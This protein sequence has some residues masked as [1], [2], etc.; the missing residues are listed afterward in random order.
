[1]QTITIREAAGCLGVGS[2][3]RDKAV[4][5]DVKISGL[6]SSNGRRYAE[7]AFRESCKL[8][9]G[10]RVFF[11][12]TDADNSDGR[13]F[14]DRFGRIVN[15]RWAEGGGLLGDIKYNPK[16][17][18]AEQ[19]LWFAENDPTGIGM[20]HVAEGRGRRLDDGT[21]LVEAITKVHSVDIVDTPA[22]TK[23]LFEQK[24]PVKE[25]SSMDDQMVDPAA[26]P[27]PVADPA[28]DAG[29]AGDVNSKLADLASEFAA[30]PEW[31]KADKLK[32]LKALLDLMEH[33]AEGEAD[34]ETDDAAAKDDGGSEGDKA[35]DA[36][37]KDDDEDKMTEQLGRFKCKAAKW[38]VRK[39]LTENRKAAAL[40][41]GVPASA[42]SLVFV[43]QLVAAPKAKLDALIAD[44]KKVAAAAAAE[45]PRTSTPTAPAAPLSPAEMAAK[46]FG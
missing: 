29:D 16:H 45:K 37:P 43:E 13:K 3:D 7:Q 20:S 15:P 28:A 22:T 21:V 10:A 39:I 23:S 26:V 8:Y 46:L 36:E 30:H 11:D 34:A 33:E 4:V 25:Q 12:H 38:A 9:E 35:D 27:A 41:A 40:K 14:G 24:T 19:F 44:R 17:P 18:N 5:R 6:T 42:L 32:K 2:V 1:M 31:K